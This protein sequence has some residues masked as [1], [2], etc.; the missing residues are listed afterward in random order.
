MRIEDEA[1]SE[2]WEAFRAEMPVA[3]QW[4]YLDHAAV[5][6][7]PAATRDAIRAWSEEAAE[8]GDR[9]WAAWA[10]GVEECRRLAA[11]LIGAD[12]REVALIPNTTTGIGLVAEGFPWRPGDEVVY[13]RDEFPSNIYPWLNLASRGVAAVGLE[14]P[15]SGWSPEAIVSQCGP[16]TRLISLSWIGYSLGER[17]DLGS[18]VEAAHDRGIDVFV[19]AIQGLGVFPLDV[20]HLGIDYLAADGHKWMLGP[21]GAGILYVAQRHLEKLRPLL[22]GWHSVEHAHDFARVEWRPRATAARYEGGSWNMPGFLGLGASLQVLQRY[23]AG[24]RKSDLAERVLEVAA[25]ARRALEGV[26]A[27]IASPGDPQ[28]TSGIVAFDLPGCDLRA[29]HNH[30]LRQGVV[31]SLR[32][33]RLRISPHAYND[34]TDIDRLIDALTTYRRDHA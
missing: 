20:H 32:A 34:A 3:R 15:A 16:R 7:I 25:S 9:H 5:A 21:E 19:D 13:L 14:R 2:R 22:V 28:R 11:E 33:G 17:L 29:V 26:G 27:I 18:L 12:T 24:P 6:P 1:R 31:L 30:L 4:A 23:G 8:G 10:A